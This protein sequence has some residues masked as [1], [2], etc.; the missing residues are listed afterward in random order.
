MTAVVE[1]FVDTSRGTFGVRTT[2]SGQAGVVIAVHGF[3]DDAS[4]FDALAESLAAAG[5]RAVSVYL[6]GYAPSPLSGSLALNDLAD[7]L[8][9][10]VDWVS[11]DGPVHFVGHD[12]GAQIGASALARRPH[13]FRSAV[14]LAAAH[15]AAISRNTP[16]HPRQ[17]WLSRYIVFFQFGTLADRAVARRDFAWLDRLWDRWSPATAVPA[18]HRARVKQTIAQS[19]PAPVAMYR[20]G[21]FGPVGTVTVPTLCIVGA[22]DGCSM[23]SMTD[24]Q[25]AEFTSD[26]RREIWPDVGHFP[27]LERPARTFEAAAAWFAAH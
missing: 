22:V 26:Y 11:P 12:Y 9:S 25:A 15:P 13:R 4:T 21:G 7:D 17:L 23:P 2:G 27:Q 18:K 8:A 3:P 20:G 14:L 10:I 19:M 24:G 5:Y 1:S 6:R 16:R